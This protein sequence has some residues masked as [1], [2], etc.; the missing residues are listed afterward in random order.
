MYNKSANQL[1]IPAMPLL[2][3]YSGTL[4]APFVISDEMVPNDTAGA[5]HAK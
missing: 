4:I 5:K 1:T 3:K 2:I